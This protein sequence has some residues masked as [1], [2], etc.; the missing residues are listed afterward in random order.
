MKRQQCRFCMYA[1]RG[2]V[3]ICQTLDPPYPE[4]STQR[5]SGNGG[6]GHGRILHVVHRPA[7]PGWGIWTDGHQD[8]G[9]GQ[10]AKV[11]L[12]QPQLPPGPN[13]TVSRT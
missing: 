1:A 8:A 5:P 9:S 3:V 12:T 13:G 11:P 4:W 6:C 2:S 7:G 10:P